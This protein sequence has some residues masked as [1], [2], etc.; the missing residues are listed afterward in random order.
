RTVA[1]AHDRPQFDRAARREVRVARA[2]GVQPR[3]VR[4]EVQERQRIGHRATRAVVSRPG[5]DIGQGARKRGRIPRE[6]EPWVIGG[7]RT[8]G[9]G[10]DA[11]GGAVDVEDIHGLRRLAAVG[12]QEGYP[13]E[14]GDAGDEIR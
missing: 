6:W 10:N 7:K 8:P 13:S 12:V 4:S 5:L 3:Y 11:V 2:N 9:V 1:A 14:S